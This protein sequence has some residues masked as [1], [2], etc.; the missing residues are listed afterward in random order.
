[1]RHGS[2]E[3]GKREGL[4]EAGKNDTGKKNTERRKIQE[5]SD[6]VTVINVVFFFSPYSK[7]CSIAPL[8]QREAPPLQLKSV[9]SFRI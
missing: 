7:A 5:G 4:K 9:S 6:P 3:G 2:R 8:P 1:M